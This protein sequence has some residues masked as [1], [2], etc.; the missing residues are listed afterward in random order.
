MIDPTRHPRS[1][2]LDPAREVTDQEIDRVSNK[3]KALDVMNLLHLHYD[4]RDLIADK[5]LAAP[6]RPKASN[7]S[8]PRSTARS[9]QIHRPLPQRPHHW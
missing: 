6:P 5:R 1:L 8:T 3:L 4:L 9:M 2:M 7:A